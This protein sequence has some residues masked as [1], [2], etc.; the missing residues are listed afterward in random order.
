MNHSPFL[1]FFFCHQGDGRSG[2]GV[3]RQPAA[4]S[5]EGEKLHQ[6][7]VTTVSAPVPFSPNET[8]TPPFS[9]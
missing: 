1:L 9:G 5:R 8:S 2:K 7:T 3:N 4:V 6:A